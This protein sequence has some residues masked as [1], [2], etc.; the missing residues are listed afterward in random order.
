MQAHWQNRT[1][2]QLSCFAPGH[3]HNSEPTVMHS[4]RII[5]GTVL[6]LALSGISILC[7]FVFGQHLAPGQEGLLYGVLGGVAAALK[8]VLPIGITA[9]LSTGQRA[10]ALTGMPLFFT[11]SA[12]RFAT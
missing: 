5:I 6:A 4:A 12:Y 3:F 10:R 9:S 7:C 2:L 8:A 1:V 11:F